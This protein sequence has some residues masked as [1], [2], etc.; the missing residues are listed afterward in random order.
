MVLPVRTELCVCLFVVIIAGDA[1]FAQ[2]ERFILILFTIHGDTVFTQFQSFFLFMIHP[3]HGR[4]VR[5]FLKILPGSNN[6]SGVT[7]RTRTSFQE[8]RELKPQPAPTY[9]RRVITS[10]LKLQ[11]PQMVLLSR[12]DSVRRRTVH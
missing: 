2:T 4:V 5:L 8:V 3:G 7:S 10:N 12:S 1:S 11:S 6:A 9:S